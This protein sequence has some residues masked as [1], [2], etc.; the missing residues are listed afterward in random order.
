[1]HRLEVNIIGEGILYSA[2]GAEA[3]EPAWWLSAKIDERDADLAG[4]VGQMEEAHLAELIAG[5][6]LLLPWPAVYKVREEY[7]PSNRALPI[8]AIDEEVH[9]ALRSAASL[10]DPDFN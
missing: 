10:S 8:P 7:R 9:P 4:F 2:T 3:P 1:M 5:G 6:A